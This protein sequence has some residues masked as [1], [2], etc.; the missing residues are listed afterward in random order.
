[1]GI[2]NLSQNMS[3]HCCLSFSQNAYRVYFSKATEN[4]IVLETTSPLSNLVD[5]GQ[6]V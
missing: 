2:Y 1:M 6:W 5:I 3:F 4:S